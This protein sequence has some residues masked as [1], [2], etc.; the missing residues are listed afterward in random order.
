MKYILAMALCARSAYIIVIMSPLE[1]VNLVN[2]PYIIA[3]IRTT[4]RTLPID[5]S[6][7][8]RCHY[9]CRAMCANH[10]AMYHSYRAMYHSYRAMCHS[11]R[12]VSHLSRDVSQLSRDASNSSRDVTHF[13][14]EKSA[15]YKKSVAYCCVERKARI[16]KMCRLCE[17]I[18]P[19]FGRNGAWLPCSNRLKV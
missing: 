13:L 12:D 17:F 15:R 8:A 19:V 9:S 18:V 3:H 14:R 7:I 1:L 5:R 11:N 16:A 6:A 4:S 10:H 2:P